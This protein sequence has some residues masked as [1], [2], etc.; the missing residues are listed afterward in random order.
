MVAGPF[1]AALAGLSTSQSG[2]YNLTAAGALG[3]SVSRTKVLLTALASDGHHDR[4][5][6]ALRFRGID[7][8]IEK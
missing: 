5:R 1:W 8:K 4:D 6:V 3:R 7:Y 2:H